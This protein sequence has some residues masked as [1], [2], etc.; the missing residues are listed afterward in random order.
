MSEISNIFILLPVTL[1]TTLKP[2][3]KFSGNFFWMDMG[4]TNSEEESNSMSGSVFTQVGSLLSGYLS[5]YLFVLNSAQSS[6]KKKTIGELTN[7]CY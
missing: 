4:L 7:S 2:N 6:G 1:C 3:G 5:F